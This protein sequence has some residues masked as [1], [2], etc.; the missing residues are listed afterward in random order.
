MELLEIFQ[1]EFSQQPLGHFSLEVSF[2]DPLL[3]NQDYHLR[4]S[5]SRLSFARLNL[6]NLAEQS[7]V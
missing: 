1:S 5:M 2:A 7:A 4:E 6:S 3:S